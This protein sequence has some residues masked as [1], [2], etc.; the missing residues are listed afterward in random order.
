MNQMVQAML[1]TLREKCKTSWKDH[2]NKDIHDYN[3][4]KHNNKVFSPYYLVF[5]RKPR[6]LIDIILQM[7][8]DPPHSTHKQYLENWK[9]VMEDAYAAALQNSTYRK[10]HDKERTLQ[11]R[12]R[13]DKLEQRDKVLVRDLIQRGGPGKLRPYWEPEIVEVVSQYKNDVTYEIKSKSY[14]T[15]PIVL[16]HNMLKPVNHSLDTIDTVATIS[17]MT[18]KISPE[19]KIKL[20][21]QG[22]ED[23]RE[24]TSSSKES[25][26]E[27]NLEFTPIQLL[28]IH[29]TLP[30]YP[31][32]VAQKPPNFETHPKQDT[33][34]PMMY[35]SIPQDI[36]NEGDSYH[37]TSQQDQHVYFNVSTLNEETSPETFNCN[38]MVRNFRSVSDLLDQPLP[39]TSQQRV[40][41]IIQLEGGEEFL[42]NDQ[43]PVQATKSEAIVIRAPDQR[44]KNIIEIQNPQMHDIASLQSV[45]Q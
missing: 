27:Y 13:L 26:R 9:E 30:I 8:L 39:R 24:T 44:L 22:A 29:Q 2:V 38:R 45:I 4:T 12:Q 18:D 10:K 31:R 11:A 33:I 42:S 16:R 28:H 7:E 19:R 35:Y 40:K 41:K 21:K 36:A 14:P 25:D 20:H 5:G 43:M 37:K 1:K 23:P 3:C 17:P 6:L 15:K 32:K 34:E